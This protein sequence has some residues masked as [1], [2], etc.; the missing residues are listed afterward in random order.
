MRKKGRGKGE[1]RNDENE[2]VMR[3]ERSPGKKMKEHE[4]KDE[5]ERIG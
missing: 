1:T 4:S 3:E 5:D 2:K